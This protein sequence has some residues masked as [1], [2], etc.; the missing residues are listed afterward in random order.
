MPDRTLITRSS[1]IPI[2]VREA[3]STLWA[4]CGASIR[5]CAWWAQW[6]RVEI[7]HQ[8]RSASGLVRCR[9]CPDGNSSACESC[10]AVKEVSSYAALR[11]RVARRGRVRVNIVISC[12]AGSA[13][14]GLSGGVVAAKA[15]L[16]GRGRRRVAICRPCSAWVTRHL[17]AGC[18]AACSTCNAR[19][20]G[21]RICVCQAAGTLS[22]RRRA[23]CRV[24]ATAAAVTR[25]RRVEV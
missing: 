19:S 21:R 16:A 8:C 20:A 3:S 2:Q 25:R 4:R 7:T 15:R 17:A 5:T 12:G 9:I 10:C 13:D 24:V 14:H 18:V 23:D 22:A 11:V 1:G 6:T